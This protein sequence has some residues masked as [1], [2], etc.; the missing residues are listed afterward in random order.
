[1]PKARKPKSKPVKKRK[2]KDAPKRERRDFAQVAFD[3]VQKAT[4]G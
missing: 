4:K 2:A 3:T 1:M